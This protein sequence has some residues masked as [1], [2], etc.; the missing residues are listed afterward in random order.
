MQLS[1][2]VS[3]VGQIIKVNNKRK[4][5]KVATKYIDFYFHTKSQ[6]RRG[7][8]L[9]PQKRR[10]L[11]KIENCERRC[12]L[13]KIKL[14]SDEKNPDT[15]HWEPT[16]VLPLQSCCLGS[17]NMCLTIPQYPGLNKYYNYNK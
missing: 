4:E 6:V 10:I 7:V 8:C 5:Q 14:A 15:S 1:G 2:Y 13:K 12:T 11:K 3:S 9:S 16:Q 17:W